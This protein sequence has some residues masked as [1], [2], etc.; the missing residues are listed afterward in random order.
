MNISEALT[1]LREFAE[2]RSKSK[3]STKDVHA[4]VAGLDKFAQA[5]LIVAEATYINGRFDEGRD[6]QLIDFLAAATSMQR[7]DACERALQWM[8]G[9]L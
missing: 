1:T 7:E 2:Y 9:M 6:L 5:L 8:G 3:D 4:K